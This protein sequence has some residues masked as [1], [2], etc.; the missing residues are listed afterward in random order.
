MNKPAQRDLEA[1]F[2]RSKADVF[3]SGQAVFGEPLAAHTTFRIGGPAGLYL[4]PDADCFVP[5]ITTLLRL[6][7]EMG[8]PVFI[9]GGG[10]NLLID[11]AG[12]PGVVLD[13]GGWSG[14][15]GAAALAEDGRFILRAG[16]P[17]DEAVSWTGD[18]G[19]AGLESFAGLPGTVGG[20]VWMNARCYE[21]ET[22]DTLIEVTV[23]DEQLNLVTAAVSRADFS[24]KQSPF[25]RRNVV[26]VNAVFMLTRGNQD[27]LRE[28]AARFRRDREE[29]GHFRYPSAGSVFKNNREHGAP[30]GKIIENLGLRGTRIGG[31]QIAPWHGN[32]IVNT[33]GATADDV[34]RLIT[35]VQERARTALGIEL[36]PE[37]LALP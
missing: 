6:S 10:A 21:Q 20:A 8:I 1:L 27:E 24:Y 16:T 2:T 7:R 23:L 25:Q 15:A 29:K 36:E 32:F 30:A 28:K 34:R 12:M 31:A 22:A 3:F 13:T 5:Y 37:V 19:W 33:G 14:I 26:I 9:L 4:K 35:L 11:D 18:R 17:V